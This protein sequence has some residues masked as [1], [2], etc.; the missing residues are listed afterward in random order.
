MS[1]DPKKVEAICLII[2][3]QNIS[4]L[5][6]LMGLLSYCS[7]MIPDF[8]TITEPLR[9]LTWKSAKWQWTDRQHSAFD[10]IK[11][12][13]VSNLVLAFFDTKKSSELIVDAS[14]YG[15]SGILIQRDKNLDPKVISYAS[16][17]LSNVERDIPKQNVRLSLSFGDLNASI[18]SLWCTICDS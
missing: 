9:E 8:A 14:P 12:I 2:P 1:V 16:R 5:R 10:V 6:S 15:L 4:E 17:S 11:G 7:K 3:P 13:V 18:V